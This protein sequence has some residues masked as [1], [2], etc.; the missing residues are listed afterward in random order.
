MRNH[1]S[2]YKNQNEEWCLGTLDR[3]K[4]IATYKTQKEAI[5]IARKKVKSTDTL[6]IHRSDGKVRTVTGLNPTSSMKNVKTSSSLSTKDINIA[7][8]QAMAKQAV[9]G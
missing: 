2:V 6:F 7:I 3:I 1:Y 4:V 9:K 8:A 5:A